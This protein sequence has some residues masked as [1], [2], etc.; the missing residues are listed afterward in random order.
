MNTDQASRPVV[1]FD[2]VC[3]VC[4]ATV[5]FILRHD[6]KEKFLFASLQGEYGRK[7]LET[8]HLP[9][10]NFSSFLLA[11]GDRIFAKSTGALE[12][13]RRLGGGWKILYAF[14]LIPTPFRDAVYG[15]VA[16]NRYRWFGK[17]DT[18][19][20]PTPALKRRFLD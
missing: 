6:R 20:M 5:Q 4:N 17:Q 18:C 12:L 15:Y 19:Y 10:D 7:V 14:I 13:C 9:S 2:G 16:R 3:N 1:L 8:H 11:D